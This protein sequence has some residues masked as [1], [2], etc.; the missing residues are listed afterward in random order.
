MCS[1]KPPKNALIHFV[2]AVSENFLEQ[3]ID[4]WYLTESPTS[5]TFFFHWTIPQL[6]DLI[7]RLSMVSISSIHLEPGDIPFLELPERR[8]KTRRDLKS[9]NFCLSLK[10]VDMKQHILR[11]YIVIYSRRMQLLGVILDDLCRIS[12]YLDITNSVG[13]VQTWRPRIA[14]ETEGT[15]FLTNPNCSNMVGFH[16]GSKKPCLTRTSFHE[17]DFT[18]QWEFYSQISRAKGA[19]QPW[20]IADGPAKSGYHQLMDGQHPIFY[21]FSII[22]LVEFP[23]NGALVMGIGQAG[24]M[25]IGCWH[26]HSAVEICNVTT[27]SRHGTFGLQQAGM[28]V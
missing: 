16:F 14:S 7:A 13:F 22:L 11:T 23:S 21:R 5:P 17:N 27:Q 26:L 4:I 12:W 6:K 15:D 18:L 28:V 2:A 1:G 25:L 3:Q 8:R 20:W 10:V 19:L 9:Y 24:W